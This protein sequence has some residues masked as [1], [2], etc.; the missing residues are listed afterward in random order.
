MCHLHHQHVMS[1]G[2][3]NLVNKHPWCLIRGLYCCCDWHLHEDAIHGHRGILVCGDIHTC[4]V[5]IIVFIFVDK[6]SSGLNRTQDSKDL[7]ICVGFVG[8]WSIL[9][10]AFIW[11]LLCGFLYIKGVVVVGD[12]IFVFVVTV[13]NNAWWNLDDLSWKWYV[14]CFHVGC[15]QLHWLL[16]TVLQPHY[17]IL[18]I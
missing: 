18:N 3:F 2:A 7:G 11:G 10:C 14:M 5:A 17:S 13:S 12:V 16:S 6:A 15:K 8:F 4:C 1:L 9:S